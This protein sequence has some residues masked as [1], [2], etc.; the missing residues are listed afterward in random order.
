MRNKVSCVAQKLIQLDPA[1]IQSVVEPEAFSIG[2]QYAVEHRAQILGADD[3]SLNSSVIGTHGLYAQNLR[4]KAGTLL[5]KCSCPLT[6]QPFCRHCVAALLAYYYRAHRQD[7]VPPPTDAKV[8]PQPVHIQPIEEPVI[9]AP[10]APS[11]APSAASRGAPSPS[12]DL[13]L[14]EVTEFVEWM[15]PAVVAMEGQDDLPP[16]P[17]RC[18]SQVRRWI[19]AVRSLDESLR[20]SESQRL[21]QGAELKTHEALVGHLTQEL[22]AATKAAKEAQ[23]I[24]EDLRQELDQVRGTLTR[25]AGVERDH[26][27]LEG[28][29]QNLLGEIRNKGTEMDR[30]SSTLKGLSEALKSLGSSPNP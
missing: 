24:G 22:E 9:N 18:S 11:A 27:A 4:L 12:L 5:T 2:R 23:S 17:D 6:E 16:T 29:L 21:T 25:L 8:A 20:S 3:T 14:R 26:G 19:Q 15:Q 13:G 1:M 28:K 10:P 30:L 7:I